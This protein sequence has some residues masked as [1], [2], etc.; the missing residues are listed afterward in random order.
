[1][2]IMSF[3]LWWYRWERKMR[4]KSFPL[5]KIY[6]LFTEFS[7]LL[8]CTVILVGFFGA[9]TSA[10]WDRAPQECKQFVTICLYFLVNT[11]KSESHCLNVMADDSKYNHFYRE[12]ENVM[13]IMCI[14]AFRLIWTNK[15]SEPIVASA[16]PGG[17]CT[18]GCSIKNLISNTQL[19]LHA[20]TSL[21]PFRHLVTQL[22]LSSNTPSSL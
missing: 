17:N 10:F 12:V 14:I 11:E 2:L 15:N 18:E 22:L 8:A 4:C 1:M 16:H 5:L 20:Q 3:S 6:I 21:S 19:L 13:D 7:L 9:G